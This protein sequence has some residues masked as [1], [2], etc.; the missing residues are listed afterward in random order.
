LISVVMPTYNSSMEWLE[1]CID[2]VRGQVYPNWQLC[3]ADDASSAPHMRPLLERY[4]RRDARI[5]VTFREINGHISAASNSALEL[6]DGEWIALLDHDDELPPYALYEVAKSINAHPDAKLLYSDEDKIDEYG[7]RFDPYLKPDWNPLLFCG[8]NLFSHLGVYSRQL[9]RE[10]GGFR[11]GWEGSQDYDLAFRCVERV[12]REQIIHIPRVLYHWR[13]I[14]GS[15]ALGPD[16]KNYA[17]VAAN[18]AIKAH[19]ERVGIG[20]SVSPIWKRTGNWR[21][22][23]DLPL[24]KPHVSI[25]VPTRNGGSILRRC[26]ESVEELTRYGKY[27]VLVVDNQSDQDGTLNFLNELR[28]R[29]RYRVCVF[30]EPFNF[31]RINNYA[32]RNTSSDV[33]VFLNDDTEVITPEWLEELVSLAMQPSAGAVGAMLYYPSGRIQHAG[34]V[35]GLGK[36]RIAGH[37][38]HDL[39]GDH[40]GD[41]CRAKLVQEVSAVTAACMAVRRDRFDAVTGFDEAFA[42]AFN[43]VDLCLRLQDKGWRN[44]WTPNA[45]LYHHESVTRG[46][47]VVPARRIEY[48]RECDMMRARW[49]DRLLNDPYYHPALS[50]DRGDFATYVESRSRDLSATASRR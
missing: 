23:F 19:F 3:I 14:A 22:R 16:E 5:K 4:A 25:I 26:L 35:L 27:D 40:P 12:H 34:I 9:V 44:I 18:K 46:S 8:H 15:T 38:Y 2:S 11:T 37:A 1:R 10:V 47:D 32:V 31:S 49:G 13:A 41:K 17:H 6:A 30:D 36:E 28:A 39:L 48:L 45:K 20:A 50:L 21:V 42:V 43:D 24:V 7:K 33:L 29:D